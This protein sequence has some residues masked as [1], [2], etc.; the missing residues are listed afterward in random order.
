MNKLVSRGLWTVLATGGFL[1]LGVGVAHA[2]TTT[3]GSDGIGSGTQGILG[4][5]IP[6]TVTGNSITLIG[7][8]ASSG[9]QTT[10]TTTASGSNATTSGL[11]SLLGG[12]QLL[13][14]V[15]IPVTVAGN[16][17]TLI[18]NSNTTGATVNTG[19]AGT[20]SGAA[21]TGTGGI[22]SGSQ[23]DANAVVPVTVSGN[24][25]TLVGDA[26]S[27][28]STGGATGPAMGAP[29]LAL[30]GITGGDWGILGGTQLLTDV[31]LPIT[32]GGNAITLLG[33]STSQGAV[34]GMP[35][36]DPET[37][38]EPGTEVPPE[39]PDADTPSVLAAAGGAGLALTGHGGAETLALLAAL[40]VTAGVTIV[41]RARART[42]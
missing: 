18:G 3:E 26:R 22:V 34:D 2:D 28:G 11:G 38:G 36:P 41:A 32:V 15:G 8:S 13:G 31:A 24:A 12:T 14:D 35:N 40:L 1:A 19:T 6:V 23:V 37:P 16:S 20:G 7:D 42:H 10:D 39:L 29:G 4:L 17:L 5:S 9:T 21:T 27:T 33:D 30:G 25:I